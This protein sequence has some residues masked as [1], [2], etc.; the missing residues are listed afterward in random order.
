MRG[1]LI[2]EKVFGTT[3][4]LVCLV[5]LGVLLWYRV[6][7]LG[8]LSFSIGIGVVSVLLFLGCHRILLRKAKYRTNSKK[9]TTVTDS[10]IWAAISF[11]LLAFSFHFTNKVIQGSGIYWLTHDQFHLPAGISLMD[12]ISVGMFFMVFYQMVISPTV[13]ILSDNIFRLADELEAVR[14]RAFVILIAVFVFSFLLWASLGGPPPFGQVKRD[15]LPTEFLSLPD[16]LQ[17]TSAFVA[18]AY[19]I[20]VIWIMYL[21]GAFNRV[22]NVLAPQRLAEVTDVV[23]LLVLGIVIIPPMVVGLTLV[24]EKALGWGTA[25]IFGLFIYGGFV[26]WASSIKVADV[27][28]SYVA[29][30]VLVFVAF[31]TALLLTLAWVVTLRFVLTNSEQPEMLR[32]ALYF[33]VAVVLILIVYSVLYRRVWGSS[34][35]DQWPGER[36]NYIILGIL[37]AVVNAAV[38]DTGLHKPLVVLASLVFLLLFP[39]RLLSRRL[40]AYVLI[41]TAPGTI[42]SIRENLERRGVAVSSL[43]GTYGLIAHLEVPRASGTEDAIQA[44]SEIVT[45]KIRSEPGVIFTETLLDYSHIVAFWTALEGGGREK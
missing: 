39:G 1:S 32:R 27:A 6:D 11:V 7:W 8:P 21:T 25:V 29:A 9:L 41:K 34:L 16:V 4:L 26:V 10:A 28:K 15:A 24:A 12:F 37:L 43:F 22:I 20:A 45:A 13:V 2:I 31:C 19:A 42:S 36:V 33:V 14:N 3:A 35:S 17:A 18:A 5:L 23:S 30:G 44:L 38:P 40:S